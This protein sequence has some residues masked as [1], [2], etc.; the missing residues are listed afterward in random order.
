VR[1]AGHEVKTSKSDKDRRAPKMVWGRSY[2]KFEQ[3]DGLRGMK[4]RKRDDMV[5]ERL[6]DEDEFKRK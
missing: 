6:R 1:L 5:A 3:S 2:L 4:K